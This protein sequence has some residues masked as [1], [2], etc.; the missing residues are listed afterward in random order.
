MKDR[1]QYAV[2]QASLD[3]I[4]IAADANAALRL[5]LDTQEKGRHAED[6][7]LRRSQFKGRRRRGAAI[8]VSS[9][10]FAIGANCPIARRDEDREQP[11]GEPSF[12][13]LRKIQLTLGLSVEERPGG[14][15]AAAPVKT[16]QDVIVAIE[17][18][19]TPRR[20]H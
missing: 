20:C 16:Q 14:V 6:S 3:I 8:G 2:L 11:P 17:D 7:P 15:G 5:P 19:H 1:C 13:R 10:R 9:R 4:D 18:R 12:T